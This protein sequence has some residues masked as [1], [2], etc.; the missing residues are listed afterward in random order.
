MKI[1]E[2]KC[3]GATLIKWK[4]LN[5]LQPQ[6]LKLPYHT[7]KVKKSII[8]LGFAN[9]FDVWKDP[10]NGELFIC[11]GHGRCDVL[12]ELIADGF[13]VPDELPCTFL[14]NKKI[15]TK[16][17]AIKYLLRVFN[18]KRNPI[19]SEVLTSWLEE[20]DLSIEDVAFD[21]LDLKIEVESD[22]TDET[23]NDRINNTEE[24]CK[25]V[26]KFDSMM[27][28]SVLQRLNAIKKDM[29]FRTNEAVLLK[30]LEGYEL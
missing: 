4:T 18:V 20:I 14:D 17:E 27:H 5:D 29:D 13:D 6:N 7:E 21:D 28:E 16:E 10:V 30:L 22:E 26:F 3:T 23:E 24:E 11:D 12:K 25:I 8:E 19:D 9:P 1:I 2:N 15:K